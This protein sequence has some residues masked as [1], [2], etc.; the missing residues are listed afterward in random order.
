MRNKSVKP[1]VLSGALIAIG[2]VLPI[3]FHAIGGGSVLLP[4][5]IP[6]LIA[7]FYLGVPFALAVG[8]LTPL[9][10]SMITGMPPLFPVLP[11]MM[12]ELATYGIM[13]SVLYRKLKVNVY[14]SLILSMICGRMMAGAT[15]WVLATF[16]MAKLPSPLIFISGALV[17]GIPGILVQLVLIPIVVMTVKRKNLFQETRNMTCG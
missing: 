8:V 6:V 4:M 3:V 2:I 12:V 14:G 11:F 15:V 13:V 7:G 9:L 1:L 16:F 17:K 10:S 5:H